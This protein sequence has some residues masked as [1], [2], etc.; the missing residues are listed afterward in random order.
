MINYNAINNDSLV[1][2]NI[3]KPTNI[4]TFVE[5]PE[6][7]E[8]LEKAIQRNQE[9]IKQWEQYPEVEK[10]QEYLKECLKV[11]YKIMTLK[12]F[13]ELQKKYYLDSPM[14]E[15]TEDQYNDMLDVLPPLKW[16]T[17]QGVEEFLI[18]EM[19]SGTYTNQYAKCNGKYYT[20]VVDSMDKSTWIHN[21]L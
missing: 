12:E 14:Q 4:Y 20:K 10:F 15:I 11:N 1:V 21:L 19:L 16:T 13:D 7:K 18:S 3:S 8:E 9:E 17:I 6:G 2:V 5:S